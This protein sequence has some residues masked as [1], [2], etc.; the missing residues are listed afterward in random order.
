M[1]WSK[2]RKEKEKM[3]LIKQYEY[4]KL[5]TIKEILR[6]EGCNE[7][8]DSD[9]SNRMYSIFYFENDGTPYKFSYTPH[10]KDANEIEFY[11]GSPRYVGYN[12]Y[13]TDEYTQIQDDLRRVEMD[14][15]DNPFISSK[16]KNPFVPDELKSPFGRGEE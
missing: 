6:I 13:T 4:L 10:K 7:E 15:E 16:L 11:Y 3:K 12:R 9:Y 2:K 5:E 1:F 14:I 8:E